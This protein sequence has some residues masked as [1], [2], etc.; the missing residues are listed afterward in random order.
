MK[1]FHKIL[2]Y[3]EPVGQSRAALQ[4]ALEIAASHGAHLTLASL[5]NEI[6][7]P[8][9]NIQQSFMDIRQAELTDLLASVDSAGVRVDVQVGVGNLGAVEVIRTVI[10][11]D[12]DL[13]IKPTDN[14]SRG[15][16]LL[17]GSNDQQLLRQCPVP[18]WII[19]PQKKLRI[20]NIL[21]AVDVDPGEPANAEL[22]NSIMALAL[23][24]AR[25]YQSHLHIAHAWSLYGEDMLRSGRSHLP[26]GHVDDM[27]TQAHDRHRQWL[28]A[29][30]GQCTLGDTEFTMHLQKGEPNDVL[31]ELVEQQDIDLTVMG[32]VARTGIPGFF[33]GNTAEKILAAIDCSV[34]AIKP[35]SFKSP[36]ID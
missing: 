15:S 21:A 9:S 32:T 16:S 35:R 3:A 4:R 19:K 5:V 14:A 28:E 27:V 11:H 31:G 20:S 7:I 2:C 18:V 6:P 25:Q 29:F 10:N 12:Y 26:Q 36:I 17:F 34:L 24:L 30:L 13:V 33:I 23:S 8:A 22:N 1:P